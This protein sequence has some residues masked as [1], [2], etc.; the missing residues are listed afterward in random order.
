VRG[1]ATPPLINFENVINLNDNKFK[2]KHV[3]KTKF[4]KIIPNNIE[5]LIN[6]IS[7]AFWVAGDGNYNKINKVIRLSTN[8]YNKDEVK[9]LSNALLNKFGIETRLEH[10][11]NNQYILIIKTSQVPKFQEL[12]KEHLHPSLYYRIGLE[13]SKI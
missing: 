13:N 12:V 4:V 3:K 1:G 5:T 6:D 8:S 11:R 9:L 10:T 7:V 2:T